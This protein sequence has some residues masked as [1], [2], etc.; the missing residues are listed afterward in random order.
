MKQPIDPF[1]IAYRGAFSSLLKWP[2]LDAF[3]QVLSEQAEQAER[4]WYIYRTDESPPVQAASA[5]ELRDFIKEIDR[6]LHQMH[7]EDYCGI[8]YTD[9]KTQPSYIKIYDPKNLGVVCGIGREPVFPGWIISQ[10]APKTLDELP[11]LPDERKPW[12]RRILSLG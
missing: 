9:S 10:L 1:Y 7:D 3:W 2:E 4:G 8:V 12:W 11:P 6:H 5:G